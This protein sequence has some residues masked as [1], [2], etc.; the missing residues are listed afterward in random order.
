VVLL[1]EGRIVFDGPY[2]EFRDKAADMPVVRPYIEQM[3]SLQ[4]RSVPHV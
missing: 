3:P 2:A 1:H 4:L